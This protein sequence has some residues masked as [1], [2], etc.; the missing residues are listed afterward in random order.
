MATLD[1][2]GQKVQVGDEFLKLT[3]EQQNATVEEISRTLKPAAAPAA[4]AEP[5]AAPVSANDLARATAEGVPIVGGLLNKANAA[6]NAILAPVVEPFLTPSADDIGRKGEGLG[7]RYRKSLAIQEGKSKKFATEHPVIDTVAKVTG[8]VAGTIPAMAAAPVAFG[9]TGTLP[10]MV[11]RGAASNAAL[12]GADAA[13]RGEDVVK[14][15]EFGGIV[16]GAA[17]VVGRLAGKA[18]G[19]VRNLITPAP[20]PIAQN[21]VEVAGRKIPMTQGQMAADPALQAEEEIIRRGARGGSAEAI[22]RQADDAARSEIAAATRTIGEGLDPTATVAR[23]AP[24]AAGELVGAELTAQRAAQDAALQRAEAAAAG[25][26]G[27]IATD[28][29]GGA[30]PVD[31]YTAAE[32]VGAGVAAQRDAA[33]ARTRERYD[34]LKA[35]PG[36]FDPSVPKGIG[37]DIRGRLNTGDDPLWVDPDTTSMANDAIKLL[38]QTIGKGIFKNAAAP[39]GPVAQ[40]AEAA[41]PGGGTPAWQAKANSMAEE[42]IAAG[43]NPTRAR[44]AAAAAE[45]GPMAPHDVAVPGGGSVSV[46]PKVVEASSIKTSADAGYDASLQPRNRA[47]AASDAQVNDIAGNL[48][49]SRL[50]VSSEA[51]RGAPIIGADGMVESG[52]GRTLAIRRAYQQ[53]GPQAQ[54][55]REWLESQGVD[56][57]KFK[58]PILVRERTTAMTPD[59]RKAFTVGSNQSATLTLSAPER[60]LADA[61]SI[62][63]DALDSIRNPADLGAVDNRDFVRQFVSKLPQA[64]QGAMVTASGDLSSE[65]LARVRNAVLAKAYGDTPILTRVSEST[66]DDIKSIS[67][68]LTAAAPEWAALKAA[69]ERGQV[70]AE[71]DITKELLDAVGRTAKIRAK[72]TS[73]ESAMAQRDAFGAQTP[74]SERIM[75]MFYGE[76]GKSAASS[77]KIAEGLRHYAKEAIK[78]DAAPGLG[79]GM[80][81]VTAGDILEVSAKKVGA[82][83]KVAQEV[84]D[85]G[86]AAADAVAAGEVAPRVGLKEMD[87]A[88][89][90]LVTM[91]GDARKAAMTGSGSD[92]RAM[93]RILHEF[94]NAIIDAFETGKFSGDAA[95][96]QDLLRAA[97]AS[98]AEY[99]N[100]FTGR[101]GADPVGRA[102][103]KILGR[104][105][106]TKATPDEIIK[107]S[108]G[109]GA[110]PGGGEAVKVAVRLKK[111]LG[112]NSAQWG[113][114]KQGLFSHLTETAPGQAQRSAD[115]VANRIDKFLTAPRGRGLAQ[116]AF[117][118]GERSQLKAYAD[119]LRTLVPRG[120]PAS[121][122]EKA[123]ARITGSD[124]HLPASPG[125]VVDMMYSRSG[126]A[127][128]GLSVRLAAHLKGN[129]SPESWTAVRQGMW[130]K[131]TNAGEG[132]VP[133]EAQALSQRLHEFLNESGSG[134][135]KVMFTQAERAEIAKLAA[136][137]K[138]MIPAKGTTNPSGSATIGA[139]IAGKAL[140]NLGAML[141]FGAG[142]IPGAI[143][144]HAAQKAGAT[145][146]DARAAKEA[147]RLFFGD[148]PKLAAAR[149][150]SNV[151][152]KFIAPAAIASQR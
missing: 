70:P 2:G 62:T 88:R 56:I 143:M 141:G 147:A 99:R 31:P 105:S 98:H 83:A 108:Y 135:A 29:G 43:I 150:H 63:G 118:Q 66:S 64:E 124:G 9:L 5:E 113:A 140:D 48:N 80:A 30:A 76:D 6:T 79:L 146:K 13:V 107:L 73:L 114:Y 87:A 97:R 51:D 3:P 38:D 104:Y 26:R 101:G 67:N 152:A 102:V 145:V 14:G 71:L 69:V 28:L 8:G 151:P 149:R 110:E 65:G 44:A 138:M 86:M 32:S 27:Q 133:F 82:P 115:E 12:A 55:Y 25:Q 106:D 22:A 125:E 121:D 123:V 137:H 41:T 61:R 40:A 1:I 119:N 52:N 23:T 91:Y 58:E 94:D 81:P 53:N 11:V 85:K 34:A 45:G 42:M 16:G 77:A 84:V 111:I 60:A 142:G 46:Q 95:G 74:E 109:S 59:E 116:I 19:G 130:E 148:Q 68:A 90:R 18:I 35:A 136:A 144:G 92:E 134:L 54:Q 17:P 36:E 128:K 127:N 33:R 103:E 72:G 21:T 49:P 100:T 120:K 126:V 39:V 37:E 15:A 132:K 10:Q 4:P 78:V 129:L 139:K 131:L 75:R 96:A 47:R 50:G 57:S 24:Q 117:S 93:G 112:E 20:P 7:E 122:V 89:K